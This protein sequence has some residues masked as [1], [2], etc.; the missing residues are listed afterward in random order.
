VA[1]DA[2]AGDLKRIGHIAGRQVWEGAEHELAVRR[3]DVF[4]GALNLIHSGGVP[5]STPWVAG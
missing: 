4:G 3:R 1:Q 2:G 5:R